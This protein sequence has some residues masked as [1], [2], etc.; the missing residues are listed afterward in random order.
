MS[1]TVGID[2]FVE[3]DQG[4]VPSEG[5]WQCRGIEAFAQSFS[6]ACDP[7]LSLMIAAVLIEG[8]EAG[9][10]GDLLTGERAD[11]RHAD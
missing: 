5:G 7:S 9:Q 11:F 6:S 4:W 1:F 3:V 10:G 2:A 8:G